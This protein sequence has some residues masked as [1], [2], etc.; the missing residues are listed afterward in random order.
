MNVPSVFDLPP[1]QGEMSYADSGARY[2][3]P[4]SYLGVPACFGT[5]DTCVPQAFQRQ[6]HE[7]LTQLELINKQY[8]RLARENRTDTAS[9]LK[10]MVHEGN[11]RWDSL[12]KRVTAILRR[13]K[14]TFSPATLGCETCPGEQKDEG[15]MGWCSL[16]G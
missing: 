9:R 5:H 14:V 4:T 13:L 6:I 3:I 16:S 15:I 8:R 7:R 2:L 12:Q 11:Q 10:Q 1:S